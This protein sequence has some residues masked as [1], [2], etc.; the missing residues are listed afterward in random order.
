MARP[1][2]KVITEDQLT[3]YSNNVFITS[4]ICEYERFEL[5]QSLAYVDSFLIDLESGYIRLLNNDQ[6]IEEKNKGKEI[7]YDGYITEIIHAVENINSLIVIKEKYPNL[8]I[9]RRFICFY[10]LFKFL[11]VYKNKRFTKEFNDYLENGGKELIASKI[12]EYKNTVF[13][14]EYKT[15]QHKN[16]AAITRNLN[17]V[18]DYLNSII[19]Q[20]PITVIPLTLGFISS[21][22]IDEKT[23]ASNLTKLVSKVKR[24]HYSSCIGHFIKID[25]HTKYEFRC[26]VLYFFKTLSSAQK[27]SIVSFNH[28]YWSNDA[29]DKKGV[30]FVKPSLEHYDVKN[31][32]S[33][34][35]NELKKYVQHLVKTN[36]FYS[37]KNINF[38]SKGYEKTI[39]K[40]L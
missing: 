3:S 37:V 1:R 21:T 31:E 30:I 5:I 22:K 14:E 23:A 2:Q 39:S 33:N 20:G 4:G 19:K 12:N 34:E 36:W 24:T 11:L 8:L 7:V 40:Q 15:W 28:S 27:K 10:E 26:T 38:I 17:G 13:S 29:T 32:N 9:N 18:T 35:Y 25:Y 16:K 6:I